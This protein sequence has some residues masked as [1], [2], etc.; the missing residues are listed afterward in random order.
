MKQAVSKPVAALTTPCKRTRAASKVIP[1]KK[2][3]QHKFKPCS[4]CDKTSRQHT[5]LSFIKMPCFPTK[6][7]EDSTPLKT[8]VNHY[9]KVLCRQESLRRIGKPDNC[10]KNYYICSA[11]P[12]QTVVKSKSF[13]LKSTDKEYTTLRYN[14]TVP[15]AQGQK[16]TDTSKTL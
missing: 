16:S 3:S 2:D 9:G 13:K 6:Q 10:S 4:K 8:V 15:L 11:C 7:L 5:T 14:V 1:K 12:F